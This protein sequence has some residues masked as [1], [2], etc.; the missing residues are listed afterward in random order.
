MTIY[1]LIDPNGQIIHSN[2]PNKCIVCLNKLLADGSVVKNSSCSINKAKVRKQCSVVNENGKVYYCTSDKDEINSNRL[3]KERVKLYS[4]FLVDFIKIKKE[5]TDEVNKNTKRLLHN[6]TSINAHNIQELYALIPQEVLTKNPKNQLEIIK[7]YLANDIEEASKT[8]LRI[9]KNNASLKTEFAVFKKIYETNPVLQFKHHPIR[10]VIL[11]LFHIF[12][13][14]FTEV[15][16]YVT[17]DETPKN[18]NLDYESMHVALFHLIDNA[19]KYIL[20][21]SNLKVSFSETDKS[22]NIL[23]EMMSLQIKCSEKEIIFQEGFCGESAIKSKKSGS[24]IGMGT[25]KKILEL[26]NAELLIHINKGK[27][28][29]LNGMNYE[30][31]IFEIVFKY[32]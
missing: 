19:T 10:K 31:N 25:I 2:L 23:F 30:K 6:V 32:S 11:N 1:H 21:N 27:R 17:V 26:N 29:Y 14:D 28:K 5:I 20:P 24:G 7:S 16:V 4:S 8:F 15:G 22:F 9:A 18:I 12:F 3:F 13:Q